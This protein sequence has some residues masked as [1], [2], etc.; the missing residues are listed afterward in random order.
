MVVGHLVELKLSELQSSW[1]HTSW[2]HS[3]NSSVI[4]GFVSTLLWP[5]GHVPDHVKQVND[6]LQQVSSSQL[7]FTHGIEGAFYCPAG[8]ES[9]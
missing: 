4:H 5:V 7:L 6:S 3:L 8:H 2:P 1:Q 9:V